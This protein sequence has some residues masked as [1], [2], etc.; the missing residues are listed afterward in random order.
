MLNPRDAWEDKEAF[1][2]QA[3]KLRD[4]YTQNW[5]KFSSDPFMAKLGD[6]GPGGHALLQ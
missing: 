6:H 2:R 1:D 3:T 5:T 4:M